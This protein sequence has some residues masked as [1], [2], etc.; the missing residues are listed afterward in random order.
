MSMLRYTIRRVLQGIPLILGVATITFFLTNAIPGN[1]VDI[2]L[3]PSP[4]AQQ[5]A[6]LKAKFGLD[7][8]VYIRYINY[9]WGLFQGDLGW[10]L[11]YD[12]PVSQK[13]LERLPVTLLLLVSSFAFAIVTAIPLGVISAWR[14][15]KPVDH[16]SRVVALVG[17]ATPSFWIGLVLIIVFSYH[18]DLLPATDL[19]LPWAAPAAVEGASTRVDVLIKAGQHLILPT[20]SLGTLRMATLTRIERS[21]MLEVLNKDYVRLPKAYGVSDRTILRKHAFRNAQLPAI[22]VI[23]LQITRAL[24]GAVLTETIF[25]INGLGLLIITAIKNQDYQLIMGTTLFFGIMFVVGV[26]ITDISYAYLDPRVSYGDSD[27]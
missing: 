20:V 15:N 10:S 3:G 14:R 16:V 11:F 9:L 27:G 12:A 2:M 26:I 13:I 25:S 8:P 18:F 4:S 19:I 5:A 1:P 17:V 21:S 7:R 24:G 6:E 23:G 22:T